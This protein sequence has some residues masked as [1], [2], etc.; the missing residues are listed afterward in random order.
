[1]DARIKSGHDELSSGRQRSLISIQFSNSQEFVIASV[2]E[3]N[4]LAAQ[5]KKLDCFVAA[6]LAMTAVYV[7]WVSPQKRL[8][9]T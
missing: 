4:Q 9:Q 5:G 3:A 8:R 6:F 2:S 1:M 7:W